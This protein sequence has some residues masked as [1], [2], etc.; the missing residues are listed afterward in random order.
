MPSFT[1]EAQQVANDPSFAVEFAIGD[2][3]PKLVPQDPNDDSDDYVR[4]RGIYF[5]EPKRYLL[6]KARFSAE[7]KRIFD[8]D[9][10][11]VV[12]VR[13]TSVIISD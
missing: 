8:V 7:D 3:F 9:T 13:Y 4:L 12:M 5:Q 10:G 1:S 2:P 11:L 6:K